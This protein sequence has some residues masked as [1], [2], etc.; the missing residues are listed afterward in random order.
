MM[1]ALDMEKKHSLLWLL[2]VPAL[3]GGI[4]FLIYVSVCHFLGVVLL[5]NVDRTLAYADAYYQYLDFFAWFKDVL[6]GR[7][8]IRYA[9][10]SSL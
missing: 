10:S 6:D 5:S 2:G 9:F 1:N 7:Q 8:S 4:V 3:S